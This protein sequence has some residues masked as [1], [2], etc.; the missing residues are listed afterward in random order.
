M[1]DVAI[2]GGGASGLL[3]AIMASRTKSVVILEKYDRVGKKILV[4]GNGRC[5]MTNTNLDLVNYNSSNKDILEDYLNRLSYQETIK[6]FNDFG[7][8]TRI[9]NGNVYPYSNQA[10]TVLDILRLNLRKQ[11]VK[12][13]CDFEVINIIKKD[14]HY[15]IIDKNNNMLESKYVVI[16]TGGKTYFKFDEKHNGYK[17]LEILGHTSTSLYP[18]LVSLTSNN[19][20]LASLKGIRVKAKASLLINGVILKEEVGEVLFN[21]L[22]LSGICIF[23]L[24]S[25]A[26]SKL[27]KKVEVVL[28]LLNEYKDE[29]IFNFLRDKINDGIQIEELLAGI[30]NKKVALSI[31]KEL[32]YN[33]LIQG[34]V[35]LMNI[36]SKLKNWS[37]TILGTKDFIEAQVT[38]GGIKLSEFNENLESNFNKNL[39]VTGEVLD[40]DGI[41]GGYNL[42]WAWTSGYIVGK[43]ISDRND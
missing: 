10:S 40:V 35:Q 43:N 41:C 30:V 15:Q 6:L 17:L 25:V 38:S 5:N 23:N 19:G 13:I 29:Y 16:S 7:L 8:L 3:C 33:D 27:D 20:N 42:Q 14:N 4:T 28:D 36:I 11:N 39:Y 21:E 26:A 24:S 12:E 9:D 22:G 1:V 18:T 34:E 32:G 31:M 37:F 2:V